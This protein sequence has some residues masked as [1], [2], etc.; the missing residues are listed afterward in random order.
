MD[1]AVKF[2]LRLPLELK[3]WITGRATKHFRSANSEIVSI[4]TEEKRREAEQM[5]SN[6]TRASA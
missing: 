3:T 6:E 1:D 5:E 2:P 4:L